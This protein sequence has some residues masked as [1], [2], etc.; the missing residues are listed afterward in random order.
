MK[1]TAMHAT[2]LCRAFLAAGIVGAFAVSAAPS[3][4]APWPQ[5]TV[6]VVVPIGVGTGVDIAARLFSA[7]L[8]ERWKQPVVVENRPGADGFIGTAAFAAMHDD[9][10]LLYMTAA[11]IAVYPVTRDKLPY[12]PGRDV[13]PISSTASGFV[14][15][16][17]SAASKIGSLGELVNRARSHPGKLNYYAGVG[18]LPIIFEGFLHGEC[19]DM[20]LVSYR[21]TNLAVQDLAEGRLDAMLLTMASTLPAVNAR[22]ARFLAIAN[23]IRAPIAPEVETVTEAGY[24]SL[25]AAA[26][27]GLFG[28][29]D[30]PDELRDRL[31][32]DIQSVAA[33]R[34]VADRLAAIGYV[35]RGSTP[36]QFA[37]ALEELRARLAAIVRL[38]GAKPVR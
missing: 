6:R 17:A 2:K 1:E 33:N 21:E 5:R 30:M 28:W 16:S 20:V 15:V 19:L 27:E 22:K 18:Q 4:A 24:P 25:S 35:V 32:A 38:T 37:A 14:A 7:R 29:R 13:V 31:S 23:D 12:D 26:L 36:A 9:H 3:V 8:A 34:A 10:V 11:A